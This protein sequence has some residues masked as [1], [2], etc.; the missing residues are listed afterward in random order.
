MESPVV[1][2]IIGLVVSLLTALIIY[3]CSSMTE[4]MRNLS[5]KLDNVQTFISTFSKDI[6]LTQRDVKQ[7]DEAQ[8]ST[9][10]K[11]E[12]VQQD[13]IRLFMRVDQLEKGAA[14]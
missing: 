9:A 3:V 5:T 13:V 2:A 10:A 4:G 14:R 11:A 12:K 8:R 1:K 7:I 6:A